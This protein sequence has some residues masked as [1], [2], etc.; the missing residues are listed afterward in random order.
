MASSN[1]ITLRTIG[2]G[3]AVVGVIVL[4]VGAF[5]AYEQAN[6][7]RSW[8]PVTAQ[9]I[10]A[11]QRNE[12]INVTIQTGRADRY[13]VTW[14]FRYAING[15]QHETAAAPGTHGTYD[16][17][18]AW[19]T[20]FRPGDQVLIHYNPANPDEISAAAYDWP[21]F[22]HAAWVGCWGMGI[23]ALGFVLRAMTRTSRAESASRR[24]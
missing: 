10:R 8:T 6:V 16:Q 21:T 13:L 22:S 9:F 20:R 23:L 1:P 4:S 17:M 14:T 7:I 19:M 11:D 3:L 18:M 2:A 15:V 5:Q 12:K 24:G